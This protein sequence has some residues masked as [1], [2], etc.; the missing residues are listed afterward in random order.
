V[1][2]SLLLSESRL[3]L[4]PILHGT[5]IEAQPEQFGAYL[6]RRR[7]AM[8]PAF[9]LLTALGASFRWIKRLQRRENGMKRCAHC[10]GRFGLIRY[11]A[12]RAFGSI[13]QFCCKECER[14]YFDERRKEAHSS[15]ILTATEKEASRVNFG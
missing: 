14:A 1:V 3:P 12:H 6:V 13:I 4:A 5:E 11:T 2:G 7:R 9:A 15:P 10:R 8:T